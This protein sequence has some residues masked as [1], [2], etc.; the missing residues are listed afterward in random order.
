MSFNPFENYKS[1]HNTVS[2]IPN[3][4]PF[5]ISQPVKP[6][7]KGLYDFDSIVQTLCEDLHNK[8]KANVSWYDMITYYKHETARHVIAFAIY[9]DRVESIFDS[10]W[11][12]IYYFSQ[13]LLINLKNLIK[14][15][16][17]KLISITI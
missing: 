10:G 6:Q 4:N 17:I 13:D 8:Y 7:T 3:H 14:N 1:T 15:F 2:L 5:E 9:E 12:T 16:L 11:Y